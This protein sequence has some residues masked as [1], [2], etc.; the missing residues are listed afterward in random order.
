M[1]SMDDERK[2]LIKAQSVLGGLAPTT[3]RND[4]MAEWSILYRL[5]L[6]A[7]HTVQ[8]GPYIKKTYIDQMQGCNELNRLFRTAEIKVR[9]LG[10][11]GLLKH[12]ARH[13]IAKHE[14]VL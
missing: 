10:D 3:P 6:I 1:T 7:R 2:P 5:P 8:L 12:V 9:S 13:H 11:N 14:N 4:E